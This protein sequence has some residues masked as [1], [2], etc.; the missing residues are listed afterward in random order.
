VSDPGVFRV[1]RARK[2]PKKTDSLKKR[3]SPGDLV[4]VHEVF[5]DSTLEWIPYPGT[6][7]VIGVD[8]TSEATR[9]GLT[10]VTVLLDG[11]IVD[12]YYE[13]ELTVV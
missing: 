10:L 6:A 12:D 4:L 11:K 5:D 3:I 13:S 1:P 8:I 7:V 2:R 9:P